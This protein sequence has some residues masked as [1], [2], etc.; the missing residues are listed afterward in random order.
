MRIVALIGLCVFCV[1]VWNGKNIRAGNERLQVRCAPAKVAYAE[2]DGP[3]LVAITCDDE[4]RYR[5]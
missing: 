5:R 4:R 3:K 2:W 1:V